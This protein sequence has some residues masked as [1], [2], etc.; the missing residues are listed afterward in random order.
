MPKDIAGQ[1]KDLENTRAAKAARMEE[2]TA[3]SVEE[4]RSLDQDEAEEFDTLDLEI[5]QIDEDLV[6]FNKL[7]K[8][9][10]Q[11]AKPVSGADRE[12]ASA[13]RDP[14]APMVLTHAKEADEAFEGQMLTRKLIAKA[15]GKF[16]DIH[17]VALAQERWGKSNPRLVE[18][19]KAGVA[20]HGSGAGE[21][22]AEL[23]STDNRYM[24]DF[25]EYLYSQ[26]VYNQLPLRTVPPHITIKGM[27]G[28]AAGYWVGESRPIPVS[29]ADF[30]TV[31]LTPL[32]VAAL[33][34]MSKEWLRDS[35]PAGE[36]LIR[37]ALVE[38]LAQRIDTTFL[39]T[40]AASAGVSPA[41]VLYNVN[42]TTSAGTDTDGVINDIKELRLRFITAKNSGG[43]YWVMN[44]SLASS[45]GL[46]RNALGQREFTEI[47]ENGGR[48]EGNPVVVGENVG[49]NWLILMKPSDI[50]RIEGGSL[51]VSM[52]EHATI[53]MDT[54][55]TGEAE[56]PTAQSANPV[57]MYQTES[58]AM[59]AVT[60]MNFQKRR[61][62]AAQYITDADY[63]G[64]VST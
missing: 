12:S 27:D 49:A 33:S 19:I 47:N 56:T 32:K 37:D 31:E 2:V 55:P 14:K 5:K 40:T 17:P 11:T 28:Q 3:K 57:S 24:G 38:A 51:E 13:A 39:S 52:S 45:L 41:G 64:A 61:L 34:V 63:G 53:E 29:Q 35:T 9:Q 50:Y 1:I 4:G 23:V 42:G 36:M 6:R 16:L 62:S 26:T 22:G 18:V 43:L 44:P 20:G 15:A 21:P 25:I 46:L 30:S 58:I 10:M 48:L 60:P 8:M 59:K 7:Q 54:E